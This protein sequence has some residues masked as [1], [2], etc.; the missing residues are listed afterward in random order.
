MGF[1]STFKTRRWT[2]YVLAFI[3][4]LVCSIP[5]LFVFVSS[6]QIK[7]A[8]LS[9]S[10]SF[11]SVSSISNTIILCVG[12]LFFSLLIG[13]GSAYVFANY[14]FTGSWFF[15]TAFMLPLSIPGYIMAITY[16]SFFDY[17]GYFYQLTGVYFNMMNMGGLIFVLTICLYPYIFITALHAFKLSSGNYSESAKVL[18]TGRRKLFFK[19][20]LPLAIPAIIGGAWLAFMETLN[21]FGAASYYGIRT[22]STEIFRCWQIGPSVTVFLSLCVLMFIIIT[23]ILIQRLIAKKGYYQASK[24]KPVSKIKLTGTKNFIFS[25]LS[26]LLFSICFLI[27][28]IV[29]FFYSLRSG[30]SED[31]R[32]LLVRSYNSFVIAGMASLVILIFCILSGYNKIVNGIKQSKFSNFLADFGYAIPG[33]VLAIALISVASFVDTNTGFF[34]TGTISFLIIAYMIR[35]YTVARQPIENVFNKIPIN[36]FNASVSLGKNPLFTFF[37]VYFPLLAPAFISIFL[38]VFIDVLK[39]LPLTL[40]LRPFN[41]ETLS[42]S[43]YGYAKVNESVSQ[44]APYSL[45]IITLGV[46]AILIL[47][48]IERKNG[49][50]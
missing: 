13:V 6:S 24:S 44:A 2:W 23:M 31:L 49:I 26:F 29:L 3:P 34:I 7:S 15:E 40:I 46:L 41:F 1:A 27:P 17:G 30:V 19:I 48:R 12:V 35:F 38:L 45:L 8:E 11:F 9:E 50:N 10:I 18:G 37:K 28:V 21:D 39:E 47:K 4:V 16:S 32:V 42:T 36:V 22:M 14:S 25:F 33:S 5:L 20:A 43:V